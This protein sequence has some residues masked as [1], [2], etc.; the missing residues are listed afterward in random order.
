MTIQELNKI[1][2]EICSHLSKRRLKPAFDLIGKIISENNLGEYTDEYRN[3]E[4]TYH[5]MLKYTMEGIQDPERQ[6]IY[7]KLIVSVYE[8][9]DKLNE[10][11]RLKFSPSIEYE[12][13]RMF[14]EQFI[15]NLN[16]Y[17]SVLEDYYLQDVNHPAEEAPSSQITAGR[18]QQQIRRLFYHVWFHDKLT[19]EDVEGLRSFLFSPVIEVSYKSFIITALMLSLLRYFDNEKFNILFESY[20]MQE[21]DINQRAL[22]GLLINLVKHD[23]RLSFYPAITGR[24]KLLNE[25]PQFKI[26]LERIIIQFI[27]SK[28]TEKLQQRIRDEILP[29]MIKISPTLKDKINLDSLME[30]GL[31]E[32]RNPDWEEI[33]KDSPGLLNKMEEFSELQMEGADVFMGSFSMLKSFP[34]YNEIS[35]W[36]MPF[37]PHNPAIEGV[38]NVSDTAGK[39]LI[40]AIDKAPILCNSDKYSFCFSIQSLPKENREFLMQGLNA[41]MEQL[42]EIEKDEML[43]DSA[44][45]AEY[46]SNQYIQD[47][48]RFY[49][50]FPRRQYLEDI[51]TWRF[52]FHNKA[53]LRDML[54]ED[55][56]L[57]RNIA[58]YYFVKNHYTE[59]AEIFGDLI[60]TEKS[61][62]L[63]QKIAFC[64]QKTGMFKKALQ[65]YLK[66]ELYDIN[67]LWN[68]KKIALCYRNL[69]Q[70]DKALEYYKLAEKIEP[71]NLN[72]QL[73]IGHCLLEL[74]EFEEALKVYFK[75]EYL[76]P[77]NKKVWRPIAWCSFLTGKREQAEK[78]LS[79]LIDDHPSKHDYMN[80]GHV[81]WSRGNRKE[82]LS[83][84]QKSIANEGFT[85]DEFLGVFEEDLPYLLK[86]GVEEDDVPIMLDQLRYFIE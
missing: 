64:H 47:L 55:P 4:E 32:D 57:M 35:N 20:E 83:Y 17:V 10:A 37:F 7:L 5:F 81:Q 26:N 85:E 75:V 14:K 78:Y 79:K 23:L 63:Y 68:L 61:G 48:Y 2:A 49:K 46:K 41:E 21:I 13:K 66:A 15:L 34:F 50:L 69:K 27:R 52:D 36:F 44:K 76:A 6:K 1:Y 84:Y 45:E 24:L 65:G 22:V 86:H 71:D 62:E 19:Q 77:G 30:E 74:N 67:R 8:L 28:D 59:A 54:L 82:A 33:F 29:E 73:N 11:L 9:S 16:Q 56:K 53:P 18:H 31:S 51:F 70:P 60:K 40:E 43:L 12:H 3:L 38:M 39:Q 42:K 58:E 80:M 25:R 72:N